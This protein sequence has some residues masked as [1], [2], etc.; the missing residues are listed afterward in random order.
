MNPSNNIRSSGQMQS[1]SNQ[2]TS[3]HG[4][5][6]KSD[7]NVFGGTVND[8]IN[9]SALPTLSQ[10]LKPKN[11]NISNNMSSKVISINNSNVQNQSQVNDLS[12]LKTVVDGT[13]IL[14]ESNMRNNNMASQ[15][16]NINNDPV[17]S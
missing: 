3:I 4:T 13:K 7:I 5:T 14:T 9:T 11:S 16:I 17:D 8:T 6:K 15:N 10:A 2:N 1:I 12:L